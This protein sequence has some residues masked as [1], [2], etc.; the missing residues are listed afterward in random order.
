LL[1]TPV[2]EA[3][4]VAEVLDAVTVT[5]A[6]T[7]RAALSEDS[8]TLAPPFGLAAL[9]VTV[10]VAVPGVLRAAAE[11]DRDLRDTAAGG[12][13]GRVMAPA[14]PDKLRAL[15]AASA[16]AVLVTPMEVLV[17]AEAMVTLTT[18]TTPLAMVFG[19]IPIARHV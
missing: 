18:A 17:T 8:A 11:H 2:A 15:P 1:L 12:S 14:V 9:R 13:A 10:Q 7:V 16:A 3:V 5:E 19:L 4:N 6:G